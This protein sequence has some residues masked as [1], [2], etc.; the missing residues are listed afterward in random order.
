[1][2][3]RK[4][5]VKKSNNILTCLLAMSVM[6]ITV[7]GL[8]IFS[9][10]SEY[11]A[12][13]ILVLLILQPLVINFFL[14]ILKENKNPLPAF[15]NNCQNEIFHDYNPKN[16][17]KKY[18]FCRQWIK[19]TK[20]F[21]IK[22]LK[23]YEIL[24]SKQIA[25]VSI[26]NAI[27]ILSVNIY[28]WISI[29]RFYSYKNSIINPIVFSVIFLVFLVFEIW[30]QHIKKDN[31]ALTHR[32][33]VIL[34]NLQN[35]IKNLKFLFLA[36]TLISSM[37]LLNLW[38]LYKFFLFILITLFTT[39]TIVTVF[40][41]SVRLIKHELI[42]N[43]DI[44]FHFFNAN[45]EDFDIVTYLEKNSGVT[46]R[47]LWSILLIKKALPYMCL[48]SVAFLWFSTG[49]VQI[50]P[51][52]RGAL[53]RFGKMSPNIITPG[54]HITLPRP[55]D[56][57]DVYDTEN[58]KAI[59]IGYTSENAI[60]DNLWTENHGG[61]ENKLLLG[62]GN[63]LVS[64]NL[65][66]EYKIEDLCDYLKCSNSPEKILESAAY[67]AITSKTISTNLE[68]LLATDRVA[69]SKSFENDLVKRISRYNTGLKVASV[70]VESIHPPI[71]VAEIYQKIISAGIDAEK[72]ILQAEARAAVT[73]GDATR[74][75]D[76]DINI[77]KAKS[78]NNI[79]QA[80]FSV[81]EFMASLEAD[82]SYGSAYRYYKYLDALRKAYSNA[83]IVIIGEGIDSSNIYLGKLP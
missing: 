70:I 15:V 31:S 12:V 48:I 69:F 64:I 45:K 53:Y 35:S 23:L 14:V 9:F 68:T 1:M 58:L 22:I 33:M 73:L 80:K 50:Q 20:K 67:E 34:T 49:I 17:F 65:R 38:D 61:E 5:S 19:L 51:N 77:A 7:F 32:H 71:E 10:L 26:L 59:T 30:C 6:A 28:F 83:N 66:I 56:V 8:I 76:T 2:R 52:Q 82:K 25:V 78:Y 75:Y 46:M 81:A 29:K 42:T 41:Y 4:N 36:A 55:F 13:N 79:A 62:G 18:K 43:P 63:E 57:V 16:F 44:A 74:T 54:I 60:G 72:I 27:F 24:R 47:S 21:K 11:S 40:W 39:Q 3:N 37:P